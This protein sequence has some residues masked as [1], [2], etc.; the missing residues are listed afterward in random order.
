[1]STE[2]FISAGGEPWSV[3][4][5]AEVGRAVSSA[6]RGVNGAV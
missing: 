3:S 1:M 5:V 2:K 6:V 4:R